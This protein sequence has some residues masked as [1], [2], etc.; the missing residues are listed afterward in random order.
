MPTSHRQRGFTLIELM[1]VVAIIGILAAIAIPQ[2]SSYRQ[3]AY[4][5]SA[6][7][8]LRV[9]MTAE[10]TFFIDNNSRYI[11]VP[12]GIGPGPAGALPST[13]AS[14]G[15]G[16][17]IGAFPAP[18]NPNYVVFTGHSQGTKVYG[19]D[20]NGSMQWK[21]AAA[22]VDPATDAQAQNIAAVI[23]AAWGFPL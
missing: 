6:L 10:E 14:S 20:S 2:F 17:V 12:A 7:S 9:F 22:G 15:I 16:Y 8:S 21:I 23:P 5:A 4:D 18:N 11:A 3:R 13:V 19:G 1:I